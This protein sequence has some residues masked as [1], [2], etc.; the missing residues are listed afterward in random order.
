M[1]A[2][3]LL[4]GHSHEFFAFFHQRLISVAA[5]KMQ[6]EVTGRNVGIRSVRKSQHIHGQIFGAEYRIL[7][8]ERDIR[9]RSVY[10]MSVFQVRTAVHVQAHAGL[11][12]FVSQSQGI[13]VDAA[14]IH[15]ESQVG[16][17]SAQ[18]RVDSG[19]HIQ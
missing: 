11:E 6:F 3:Q 15:T 8:Y 18:Q 1:P 13:Q 2:L 14:H 19:T 12:R 9:Y 7:H 17:M 4:V 5:V 16:I 10:R